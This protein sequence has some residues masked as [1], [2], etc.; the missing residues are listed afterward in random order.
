MTERINDF[1]CTGYTPYPDQKICIR[2]GAG[3]NNYLQMLC[4]DCRQDDIERKAEEK[5]Q[6]DLITDLRGG[7]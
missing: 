1:C 7:L 5:A 2:C 6:Q 4:N 3:H